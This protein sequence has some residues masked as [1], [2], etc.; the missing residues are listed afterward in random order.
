MFHLQVE[1]GLLGPRGYIHELS[2]R[3]VD[4]PGPGFS[5]TNESLRDG[6]DYHT[7]SWTSRAI[8]LDNVVAPKNMIVTGKSYYSFYGTL[9]AFTLSNT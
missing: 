8:D 5:Y 3:W 9:F 7:L 6:V 2:R 1:E 4:L